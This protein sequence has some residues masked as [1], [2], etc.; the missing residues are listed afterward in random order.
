VKE[1]WEVIA[2]IYDKSPVSVKELRK[3]IRGRDGEHISMSQLYRY[4]ENPEKGGT[5][6]PAHLIP[7]YTKVF[8]PEL[9]DHL[10]QESKYKKEAR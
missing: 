5:P 1:L 8:G 6:L 10:I 9:I 3:H 7:V 2:E 4:G